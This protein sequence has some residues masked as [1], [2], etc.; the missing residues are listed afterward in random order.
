MYF[1]PDKIGRKKTVIFSLA[2]SM[3]A[4]T[5]M[6]FVSGYYI[7]MAC[8]L[9]MGLFQLQNSTSYQWL[10]ESVP[11]AKKSTAITIINS[12]YSMP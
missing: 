8:F 5:T 2:M 4:E 10:Y 1:L 7:R 3:I 11:K 12:V 9:V 6:I